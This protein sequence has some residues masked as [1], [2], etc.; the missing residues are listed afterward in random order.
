MWYG[1][2]ARRAQKLAELFVSE[3]MGR[4]YQLQVVGI[5]WTINSFELDWILLLDA[6]V[7]DLEGDVGLI[8]LSRTMDINFQSNYN[9]LDCLSV[10]HG[11]TLMDYLRNFEL[12]SGRKASQRLLYYCNSGLMGDTNYP[13]NLV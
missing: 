10:W 7:V 2:V 8:E 13:W 9:L 1:I 4:K 5:Y 11:L 12:G 6:M 3:E